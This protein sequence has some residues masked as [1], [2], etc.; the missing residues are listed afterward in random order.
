[1]L[2]KIPQDWLGFFMTM[3]CQWGLMGQCVC[4][5]LGEGR[6][7]EILEDWIFTSEI[8]FGNH[9]Y[10]PSQSPKLL[11]LLLRMGYKQVNLLFKKKKKVAL[12]PAILSYWWLEVSS[13]SLHSGM[14]WT[15]RCWSVIYVTAWWKSWA[16]ASLL[17]VFCINFILRSGW[18]CYRYWRL[19][20]ISVIV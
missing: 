11:P 10:S 20:V 7:G 2:C 16:R 14:V 4:V 19:H 3:K 12:T 8:S 6:M 9:L 18:K 1:M 15:G 5:C 13:I 17:F